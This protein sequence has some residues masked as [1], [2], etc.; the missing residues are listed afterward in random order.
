MWLQFMVSKKGHT[1]GFW[2]RLKSRVLLCSTKI[3]EKQKILYM[4][5]LHSCKTAVPNIPGVENNSTWCELT[6]SPAVWA[7]AS[8]K[9][10]WTSG[11]WALSGAVGGAVRHCARYCGGDCHHC[12]QIFMLKIGVG[13]RGTH[14]WLEGGSVG[15]ACSHPCRPPPTTRFSPQ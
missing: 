9:L 3:K 8:I 2:P 6:G 1:A 13:R 15:C 11:D 7:G 10:Q 4:F 12:E 5:F 14:R